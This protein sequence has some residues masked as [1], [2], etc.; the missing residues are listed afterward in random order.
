MMNEDRLLGVGSNQYAVTAKKRRML[1]CR[2][3][4]LGNDE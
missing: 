1:Q 3:D 4:Q 2:R